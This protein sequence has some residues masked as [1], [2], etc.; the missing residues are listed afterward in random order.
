MIFHLAE[1]L[2][3]PSILL[4]GELY[5]YSM[6]DFEKKLNM[7]LEGFCDFGLLKKPDTIAA[8]NNIAR[9]K[10]DRFVIF[11]DALD[12]FCNPAALWE[13][14][15]HLAVRLGESIKF[16]VSC[17][18]EVWRDLLREK[19]IFVPVDQV[20]M[21]EPRKDLPCSLELT[22]FDEAEFQQ[23][24]ERYKEV[25]QCRGDI[26]EQDL[27]KD[28]FLMRLL[29]ETFQ[30][31]ELPEHPFRAEVLQAYWQ[32]KIERGRE[33]K[34]EFI[35]KL[36]EYLLT[37]KQT[38]ISY[39]LLRNQPWFD[40][41]IFKE[42]V[43][44][45]VL[46]QSH[47]RTTDS[48]VTFFHERLL[49]YAVA[50]V[51]Y[52]LWQDHPDR[53]AERVD[54]MEEFYGVADY[55]LDMLEERERLKAIDVLMST[56][57]GR[58]R[59][60]KY[61]NHLDQIDEIHLKLFEQCVLHGFPAM[62]IDIASLIVKK[63]KEALPIVEKVL[64]KDKD[65]VMLDFIADALR[66]KWTESVDVRLK[67]R[68]WFKSE[69]P[70]LRTV[71]VK[72]VVTE[73]VKKNPVEALSLLYKLTF[74]ES[75][76]VRQQVAVLLFETATLLGKNFSQYS[77]CAR[78]LATDPDWGVRSRASWSLAE[79][80]STR[81]DNRIVELLTKWI[82]SDDANL[83]ETAVVAIAYAYRPGRRELLELIQS[84]SR[85]DD[86]LIKKVLVKALLS[87]RAL[88]GRYLPPVFEEDPTVF[89]PLI[90]SIIIRGNSEFRKDLAFLISPTNLRF[91][92]I[93]EAVHT[94][95]RSHDWRL[96]HMGALL[97]AR[98]RDIVTV[99]ELQDMLSDSHAEIRQCIP[100][101]VCHKGDEVS[102][103]QIFSLLEPLSADSNYEVRLHT[104]ANAISMLD[105]L[106]TED[107]ERLLDNVLSQ[108]LYASAKLAI[109]AYVFLGIFEEEIKMNNI[110]PLL[111]SDKYAEL[112]VPLIILSSQRIPQEMHYRLMRRTLFSP[113]WRIRAVSMTLLNASYQGNNPAPVYP[114]LLS[115]VAQDPVPA[116][117]EALAE[118]FFICTKDL[119]V[120]DELWPIIEELARDD[121]WLVRASL[122]NS[123]G[124]DRAFASE[125]LSRIM[126]ILEQL[127]SDPDWFV[128]MCTALTLSRLALANAE[129]L[130]DGLKKDRH[131]KV[132]EYASLT[133]TAA[134]S[135]FDL[136]SLAIDKDLERSAL[137]LEVHILT[138]AS[139]SRTPIADIIGDLIAPLI[140]KQGEK[141]KLL[142]AK[143]KDHE[144][145]FFRKLYRVI[146]EKGL[147]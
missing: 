6:R 78:R 121:D 73:K 21:E 59:V 39:D 79:V 2:N 137:S 74:D 102:A 101:C 29:F 143:W 52:A 98:G 69:V 20:F 96:K 49:E 56:E 15:V 86:D 126:P 10:Q 118:L 144:E 88:H 66:R 140:Q 87:D 81:E 131:E 106:N 110:I 13:D 32:R 95:L 31:S 64:K 27:L 4:S 22:D 71:A 62:E 138:V 94:W 47:P 17:R 37:H 147:V 30:G 146:E 107:L 44:E 24:T 38:H 93:Q 123:L 80:I 116:V 92:H 36:A 18:S 35:D 113:D 5:A 34:S 40:R 77:E 14:I 41:D 19:G 8:V 136:V 11:V 63:P 145:P 57:A 16:C 12:R 128:R 82:N 117:R 7:L 124:T 72:P 100:K 83:K 115:K 9:R 90:E 43:E 132:R 127:S 23:A 68:E 109:G 89:R 135:W 54:H 53:F 42:L 91:E 55:F 3:C 142:L 112:F 50:K 99:K 103:K 33:E 1:S 28:P 114:T 129:R 26:S 85:R 48:I 46:V 120:V 60:C 76:L 125:Q 70:S 119:F 130:L 58:S 134:P 84:V 105:R 75:P 67:T 45:G 25:F 97:A 139:I 65:F 133:D 104:L 111:K 61:I 108:G 122:A 141:T 51:L